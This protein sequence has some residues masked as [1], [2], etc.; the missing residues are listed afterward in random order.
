MGEAKEIDEKKI[1]RRIM[2]IQK[3]IM[4]MGPLYKELDDLTFQLVKSRK[5]K[6]DF[7]QKVE[8]RLF[9]N[10]SESNTK[11][12]ATAVRRWEILFINKQNRGE[13]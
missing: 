10:F 3:K 4:E 1:L 12:K 5:K 8:A 6:F 2:Y 11:F 7:N 9:D 13:K